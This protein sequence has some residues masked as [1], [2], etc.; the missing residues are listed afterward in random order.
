[1]VRSY[2][3]LFL[4]AC[5]SKVSVQIFENV[6]SA[7]PLRNWHHCTLSSCLNESKKVSLKKSLYFR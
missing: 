6:S 7:F 4:G 1:M 5:L 3:S 2:I